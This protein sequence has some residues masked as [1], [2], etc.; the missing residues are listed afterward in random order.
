L[1]IFPVY[2]LVLFQTAATALDSVVSYRQLVRDWGNIDGLLTSGDLV[3][4]VVNDIQ[5]LED[6]I[7]EYIP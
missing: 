4:E 7:R 5:P 3:L 6:S 1:N 2:G